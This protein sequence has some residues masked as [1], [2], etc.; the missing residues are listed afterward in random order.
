MFSDFS[1][2]GLQNLSK[3]APAL[4]KRAEVGPHIE[5]VRRTSAGSADAMFGMPP[6]GPPALPA[7]PPKP[8]KPAYLQGHALGNVSAEYPTT[9]PNFG[10]NSGILN[11]DPAPSALAQ[12]AW[13]APTP[14]SPSFAPPPVPQ[15]AVESANPFDLF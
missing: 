11:Q 12:M 14:I 13:T 1:S 4:T 9:Q 7:V 8:L 2:M 3:P 10:M 6:T 15:V 5:P